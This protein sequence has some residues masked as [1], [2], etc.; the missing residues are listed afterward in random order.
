[1]GICFGKHSGFMVGALSAL[2]SNMIIGQGFWTPFQMLAWGLVGL[3]AGVIADM[4]LP[5][6]INVL[7]LYV[8]AFISAFFYGLITD[9]WTRAFLAGESITLRIFLSLY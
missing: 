5:K 7:V 8:Y 1:M 2:V 3:I 6:N 9:F 4:N